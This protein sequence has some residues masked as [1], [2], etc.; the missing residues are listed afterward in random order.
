[1]ASGLT[2]VTAEDELGPNSCRK[3]QRD[4]AGMRPLGECSHVVDPAFGVLEVNWEFNFVNLTHRSTEDGS[5]AL[6][7]DGSRQEI[8]FDLTTCEMI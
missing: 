5:I 2:T 4:R 1:M 8:V 6:G 3:W 7:F